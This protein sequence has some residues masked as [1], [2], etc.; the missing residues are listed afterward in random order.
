MCVV[1]F[2]LGVDPERIP[3]TFFINLTGLIMYTGMK[4]LIKCAPPQI[5][6]SSGLLFFLI[7]GVSVYFWG[8]K[9]YPNNNDSAL[10]FFHYRIYFNVF[11]NA[12]QTLPKNAFRNGSWKIK[13]K[14]WFFSISYRPKLL[15]ITPITNC[16]KLDFVSFLLLLNKNS[17]ILNI[18]TK[19]RTNPDK[20]YPGAD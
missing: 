2:F 16:Q 10:I 11:H 7:R 6:N 3:S 19:N 8:T 9:A 17:I 15:I 12:I 1:F 13:L 20:Q 18:K 14:S 4:C 5:I